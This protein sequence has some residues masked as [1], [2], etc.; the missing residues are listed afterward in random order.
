MSSLRAQRLVLGL[1][2]SVL[3]FAIAFVHWRW[4]LDRTTFAYLTSNGLALIGLWFFLLAGLSGS[5]GAGSLREALAARARTVKAWVSE[6]IDQPWSIGEAIG[7]ALRSFWARPGVA[8]GFAAFWM[9]TLGALAATAFAAFRALPPVPSIERLWG[10]DPG[11]A[12]TKV[13]SQPLTLKLLMARDF[14]PGWNPVTP[15]VVALL[16]GG[17][18]VT[19]LVFTLATTHL[20]ERSLA[21]VRG[22]PVRSGAF[23]RALARTPNVLVLHFVSV[24][25]VAAPVGLNILS[26]S[27]PTISSFFV[28]TL[29]LVSLG[30]VLLATTRLAYGVFFVVDEDAWFGRALAKSWRVTGSY[31]IGIVILGLALTPVALLGTGSVLLLAVAV[32]FVYLALAFTY[33]RATG[34]NELPWLAAD[35]ATKS[36]RLYLGVTF[37]VLIAL[38]VGF[39]GWVSTL[40]TM[41]GSAWSIRDTIIRASAILTGVGAVIVALAFVLP[42]LLDALEG[43]RFSSFVAARHVRSPK[44]GFLT[45]ISI[46]SI[47]GVAMSSCS[48]SSVVSVMGGFSADLKRKILGNN[49]HIVVDMTAGTSFGDY[50][51]AV[52]RVRAVPGV[53][54]AMAVVHGEVMASSASNIAGVMV[55]GVDPQAIAKVNDLQSSLEVGKLDYLEHPEK[56]THL[57]ANEPIGIGPGGEQYFKQ[58]ELTPLTDDLDESVRKVLLDK[59]DRPGII[60]GRELAKTL[61]VYVGDEVTLVSPLGDLGPMGVLPRTKKFRVAGVFYSGMYE[62]DATYVYTMLDVAQDYFQS[63]DKVSSIEIKVED[64]E[65]ADLVAPLVTEA[66][67]RPDLRVRD[68]REINKNLFSALKLERFATFVILLIA[69]M[70]ASFCIVCTLLLMVTEKGKEIAILKAIGASDSAILRIFM[71]E[72]IIIGA[73]GTVFG[74]ATGLSVC[75]GLQWFGLRLDPEVYYIDK[76][77]ITVNPWDFL[78]VAAA[79][80]TICTLST[81]YPAYA[82]SRLRPVDGLRYE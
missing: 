35:F 8:G 71:I 34:R 26:A 74:V 30:S 38:F 72:G 63:P 14:P 57:P 44:S 53:K 55:S 13:T 29:S 1:V 21:A 39:A 64:A 50:E 60:L 9:A 17:A 80:L 81:L 2:F 52:E 43:K 54:G 77:P 79:A 11:A 48:L 70:V 28:V 65:R 12:A 59:P 24:V 5:K 37:A 16:V 47:C 20:A 58:S 27:A 23:L 4:D 19:V 18:A 75:A 68:W 25:L 76:L 42:Y 62:Y 10:A 61:H 45:V 66:L 32:P 49:A 46:L 56:L 3:P 22:E 67:G 7:V 78:A 41:R 6:G 36:V 31:W 73:I 69:I 15:Q 33:V 40:P 51:G 82:A